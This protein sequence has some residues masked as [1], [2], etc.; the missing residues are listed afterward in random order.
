MAKST[1]SSLYSC[2][3]MRS[4]HLHRS[5]ES[6]QPTQKR[7]DIMG[8]L[9]GKIALVTG[10]TSGIG[11]ATAKLFV[12][13]GA[14]VYVTGRRQ[15]KLDETVKEIGAGVTAVQGDVAILSDLDRLFVQI[16][17]ETGRLDIVF[18]NAGAAE[19]APFGQVD[20]AHYD[21]M[22]DGNV[23][24]L[25]FSVQKALPLMPDGST[26]VLTSSIVGSKGLAANTAYAATK[27]AIRSFART[28]ATDLKDRKIRVNAVSPGPIDTAGLREL[29]GDSPEGQQRKDSFAQIVPLGRLGS[30]EEIAKAVLFLASTDSSYVT[31]TELFVD[32]G[33]AQV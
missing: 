25:F 6:I 10:G 8:K 19:F 4:L 2:W 27:A 22:F 16:K 32:G 33:M 28:W 12:A 15:E 9:D 26:I 5:A 13:E 20:E 24:G 3:A 21:R 7:S 29:L 30:P 18:A 1:I 14:H 23:K 11:L 31:G 17:Q